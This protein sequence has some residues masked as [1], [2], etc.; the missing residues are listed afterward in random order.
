L[1][2]KQLASR[3]RKKSESKKMRRTKPEKL[4]AADEHIDLFAMLNLV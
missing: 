3:R 2:V 4:L 1:A